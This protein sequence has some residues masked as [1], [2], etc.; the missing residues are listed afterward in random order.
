[1]R[2]IFPAIVFMHE[3]KQANTP[4]KKIT[5]KI[6]RRAAHGS[7][8]FPDLDT[9]VSGVLGCSALG[10]DPGIPFVSLVSPHLSL[11]FFMFRALMAASPRTRQPGRKFEVH[12]G[13]G[14]AAGRAGEVARRRS[15]AL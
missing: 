1:M 7:P 11:P 3:S 9:D 14:S 10:T 6:T 15:G 12:W 13:L 5:K 4:S 8:T 2:L